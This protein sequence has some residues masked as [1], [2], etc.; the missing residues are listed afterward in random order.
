MTRRWIALAVAA[1]VVIAAVV[2][3]YGIGSNPPGLLCD[4]ASNGYDAYCL[5]ETGRNRLGTQWPLYFPTLETINE[6]LYR[7]LLVGSVAVFGLDEMAVR[8]PAAVAG[9]LT[10]LLL[11]WAIRLTLDLRVAVLS[12]AVLAISPWHI[13][14]SRIGF[15]VVLLPLLVLVA[16]S[17]AERG[18]TRPGWFL[19]SGLAFG[20]SMHSYIA[21]ALFVPPVAAAWIWSCRAELR[22][23]PVYAVGGAV[24]A[25]VIAVPVVLMWASPVGLARPSL[26][27]VSDPWQF[28]VNYASYFSPS[29]LF[30]DGDPNLRHSVPGFGQLLLVEIITVPVGIFALFQLGRRG[31]PWIVWILASPLAAALTDPDQALRAVPGAVGL[32]VVSAMG[33]DTLIRL[34]PNRRI[35]VIVAVGLSCA[36]V[37]NVAAFEFVYFTDYRDLSI[38]A[39]QYGFRDALA[40]AESGDWSCVYLSHR[41]VAPHLFVL[42]YTAWPPAD[43]Q[44]REQPITDGGRA[45]IVGYQLG[46][47]QVVDLGQPL[48][49]IDRCLV[50]GTPWDADSVFAAADG[51][52]DVNIFAWLGNSRGEV[53]MALLEVRA[54]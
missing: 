18:R 21:A 25:V 48:A 36:V 15:R 16:V 47:Y 44:A 37:I 4:E 49:V 33:I 5:L 54:R 27:V 52:Y 9:T 17:A 23:S 38:G 28:V 10:V 3:I 2:R 35:R 29:F 24:L 45:E 6:G 40:I 50:I 46:K 39:W 42:F 8:L 53:A 7:Y 1:A 26:L 13:L 14:I 30:F 19:V 41:I 31:R 32:A 43:Y 34:A 11:F 20:L 22:R 12:A 51:S